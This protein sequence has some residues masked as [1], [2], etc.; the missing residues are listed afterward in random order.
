MGWVLTALHNAF[1]CL[2]RGTDLAEAVSAT[3]GCGGDTDTNATICAAPLGAAQG[4][5]AVPLQWRNAVPSC[6]P[7][8]R[9]D[10]QHPRPTLYW[11]D[12]ALDLADSLLV[13]AR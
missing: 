8:D 4:R 11:P 3:V 5:E 1:Y 10:V 6:H 9:P 13:A 7:V 12:D 2:M